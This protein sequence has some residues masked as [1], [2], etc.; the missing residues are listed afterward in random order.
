MND[1]WEKK[2]V[3]IMISAAA[4]AFIAIVVMVCLMIRNASNGNHRADRDRESGRQTQTS[5][6]PTPSPS[7]TIVT[8]PS[9]AP[10]PYYDEHKSDLTYIP[11]ELG[12]LILTDIED[13][14][15]PDELEYTITKETTSIDQEIDGIRLEYNI[16]YPAITFDDGSSA[17]NIND[18][19]LAVAHTIDMNAADRINSDEFD[20]SS[21]EYYSGDIEYQITYASNDLLCVVFS[22]HYFQGNIYR[23][24]YDLDTVLINLHTGETYGNTDLINTDKNFEKFYYD[25]ISTESPTVAECKNITLKTLGE[26]L[27]T[28]GWVNSVY[29][30]DVILTGGGVTL[31]FTYHYNDGNHVSRGW[32]TVNYILDEIKNNMEYSEAWEYFTHEAN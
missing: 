20:T 18:Y 21:D 9:P 1:S 22:E 25:K 28:N 19:M 31:G 32:V 7:I 5:A 24:Y 23:E 8:S 10:T 30:T 15:N 3:I 11:D 26:S 6:R 27:K 4:L 29:K 16:E 14:Y 12:T 17:S 13:Y 2:K